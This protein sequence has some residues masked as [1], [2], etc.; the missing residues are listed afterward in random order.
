MNP[1]THPLTAGLNS[2]GQATGL[3]VSISSQYSFQSNKFRQSCA[4]RLRG[5][6]IF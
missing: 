2:G 6:D 5:G 1:I 4:W 3:L